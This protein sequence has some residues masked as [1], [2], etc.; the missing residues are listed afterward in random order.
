MLPVLQKVLTCN[1]SNETSLNYVV[2]FFYSS[3]SVAFA[4]SLS[5][6]CD[7]ID[8]KEAVWISFKVVNAIFDG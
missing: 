7:G 6:V 3:R 8:A 5:N 4:Q 2:E 1:M